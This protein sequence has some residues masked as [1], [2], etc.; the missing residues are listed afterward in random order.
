MAVRRNLTSRRHVDWE[1]FSFASFQSKRVNTHS[2]EHPAQCRDDSAQRTES[3][4]WRIHGHEL[5]RV[6]LLVLKLSTSKLDEPLD[7]SKACEG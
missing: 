5:K 2:D 1:S 4:G 3:V 6:D 7:V